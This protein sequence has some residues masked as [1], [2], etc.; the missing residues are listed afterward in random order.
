MIERA[1]EQLAPVVERLP[2]GGDLAAA[3]ALEEEAK[4]TQ[5]RLY[6]EWL[7]A[8]GGGGTSP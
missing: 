1:A 8:N 3:R 6:E 5:V 7:A 2:R 4:A